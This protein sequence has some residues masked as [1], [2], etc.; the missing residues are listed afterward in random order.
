M[1]EKY[2]PI[3]SIVTLK[4]SNKRIMIIGYYSIKYQNLVKIYD[5]FGCVYPEGLLLPDNLYSF[6]HKDII[7]I[8]FVGFKNEEFTVLNN[9]MNNQLLTDKKEMQTKENFANLK[10]DKNGVVVYDEL[11]ELKINPIVYDILNSIDIKNPFENEDPIV[12]DTV[13]P[14]VYD[15]PNIK[16]DINKNEKKE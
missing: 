13:E 6:N 3:G 11:Q 9:N 1:E 5:Y 10:Y 8:N 2:L 14:Q 16:I 12:A 15:L 7:E 4:E